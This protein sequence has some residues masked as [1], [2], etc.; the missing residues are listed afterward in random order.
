MRMD[1]ADTDQIFTREFC[2]PCIL[3]R[4]SIRHT[5]TT[6]TFFLGFCNVM[7][8]EAF[9]E[10]FRGLYSGLQAY[11]VYAVV[12]SEGHINFYYF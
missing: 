11:V 10:I 2:N 6:M 7:V 5:I 1:Q 4:F 12:A 3:K 8:T 9:R